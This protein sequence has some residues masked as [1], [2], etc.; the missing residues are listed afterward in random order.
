MWHY[1]IKIIFS[2]PLLH[3]SYLAYL[4]LSDYS[5]YL[6]IALA[7]KGVTV[8]NMKEHEVH[9]TRQIIFISSGG[10]SDLF[11]MKPWYYNL[12]KQ[13]CIKL[14]HKVLYHRLKSGQNLSSSI[15]FTKYSH[16]PLHA[17]LNMPTWVWKIL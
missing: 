8:W 1:F 10:M 16:S 13:Q 15:S 2:F 5:V 14:S 6:Q 11:H 7:W 3:F 4:L 17:K 12:E 9:C